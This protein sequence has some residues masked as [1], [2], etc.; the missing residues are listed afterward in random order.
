MSLVFEKIFDN[1]FSILGVWKIEENVEELLEFLMMKSSEMNVLQSF[2]NDTRKIQW[3]SVRALIRTMLNNPS[4]PLEVLYDK[5]N[6]PTLVQSKY[7]VSISHSKNK[8]AVI[9]SKSQQLGVDIEHIHPKIERVI[10]KF[11]S[12]SEINAAPKGF[13]IEYYHICW[14]AK[15]ALY[16]LNGRSGINFIEDI[17]ISP[18]TYKEKGEF[19]AEIKIKDSWNPFTMCYFKINDYMLVYV[20]G[21]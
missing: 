17:K 16:K 10:H 8:A 21:D 3:L 1:D 13:E 5:F 14:C 18:F 12:E 11:M 6:K 15:E 19:Y 4:F 2:K 9:L 7:N 20:T